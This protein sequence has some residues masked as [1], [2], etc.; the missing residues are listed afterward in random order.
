LFS[1]KKQIEEPLTQSLVDNLCDSMKFE[2]RNWEMNKNG[3]WYF[4]VNKKEMVDIVYTM[5]SNLPQQM[6]IN[7]HIIVDDMKNR[8]KIYNHYYS[9]NRFRETKEDFIKKW[10]NIH[11]GEYA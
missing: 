2:P 4:I 8:I 10:E 5:D 9:R 11:W 6:V 7:D 3:Q 1:F